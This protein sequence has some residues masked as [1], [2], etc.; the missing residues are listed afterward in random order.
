MGGTPKNDGTKKVEPMCTCSPYKW[1]KFG[2]IWRKTHGMRAK[3]PSFACAAQPFKMGVNIL[4]KQLFGKTLEW[5]RH[6]FTPLQVA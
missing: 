4:Y 5:S 2:A 3:T 6:M 1:T